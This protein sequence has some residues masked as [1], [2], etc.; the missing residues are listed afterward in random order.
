MIKKKKKFPVE[1]TTA[2]S[3]TNG[4]LS[5]FLMVEEI[6]LSQKTLYETPISSI[7]NRKKF[8]KSNKEGYRSIKRAP[9][10]NV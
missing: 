5:M 1:I 10:F 2:G 7:I 8:D 6:R 4:V 9:Y 3:Y